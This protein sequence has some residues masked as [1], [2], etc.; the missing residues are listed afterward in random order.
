MKQP[1]SEE[2]FQ[3]C[4]ARDPLVLEIE[5]QGQSGTVR[6]ILSLPFALIGRDERA[7]LRLDD[8][9]V[10]SRHAYLQVVAGQLWYVD[11]GSR[12]GTHGQP[13]Q[14]AA[15][16]RRGQHL[17]IDPFVVRLAEG[18]SS[19]DATAYLAN[20]LTSD[21]Y[22]PS[23]LPR[24]GLD[25]REGTA[26]QPLWMV[27]RVLTLVGSSVLCKVRL[28]SP[29]VSRT[30]CALLHTPTGMWVIDLLGREGIR[31]NDTAVRWARLEDGDEL[32]IGQFLVCPRYLGQPKRAT[33]PTPTGLSPYLARAVEYLGQPKRASLP[34]PFEPEPGRTTNALVPATQ[35][36]IPS[37]AVTGA[38]P[39]DLQG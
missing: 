12:A 8:K 3:A 31:V 27:D 37:A 7:D 19:A 29:T 25:F 36:L 1:S 35:S 2:F 17:P 26:K 13:D 38:L 14:L 18:G 5:R 23:A 15:L 24:V 22:D 6:H 4:G 11:L 20:P 10:G 34:T 30:H 28:H 21:S 16:L 9:R 33:L 39:A 32:R